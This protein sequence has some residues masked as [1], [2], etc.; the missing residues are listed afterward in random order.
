MKD[1]IFVLILYIAA[2]IGIYFVF[3]IEFW[4]LLLM[5]I[6]GLVILTPIF[7]IVKCIEN[8]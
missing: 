1:A 3:D 6:C 7:L 8:D 4:R 2:W 5:S